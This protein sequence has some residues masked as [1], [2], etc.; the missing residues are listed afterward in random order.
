[1][2]TT[3]GLDLGGTNLRAAKVLSTGETGATLLEPLD[4]GPGPGQ[5]EQVLSII[6]R[7]HRVAGGVLHGVGVAVT[8]PVDPV[9]GWVDNPFTLPP[10][11]QGDLLGSIRRRFDV[12][13]AVEN[14][15]NAAAL[16]EALYGAGRGAETVV[17]VTIGTGIGVGVVDRGRIRAGA[18]GSHPEAGHIV[19]DP[20][21]PQCYCGA[22]GCF[23]SMASAAAVISAA[24]AAGVI[25][26]H[27]SALDVQRA[28]ELGDRAA[29]EIIDRA[30][31]ALAAGVRA[32]V[33]VYAPD[34]VVLAGGA[35]GIGRGALRSIQ[36][37]AS[38]FPF[39][40]RD[41]TVRLGELGA[42]S[43]C[44]GAAALIGRPGARDV[45]S[46]TMGP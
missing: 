34:V 45:T 4:H 14:D 6:D 15:A 29:K 3:I 32:L 8:G 41:V 11:M 46:T 1:M 21:G 38:A 44:I 33:A 13:A 42:W 24:R 10:S 37:A 20:S 30:A 25:D 7:V 19:I 39:G 9:S 16:G 43:G 35:A 40:P 22:A 27:G 36:L 17:C 31:D 5:F 12:S 2:R 28:V 26:T 23:E 18:G